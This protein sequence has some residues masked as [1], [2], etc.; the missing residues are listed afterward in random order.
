MARYMEDIGADLRRG[1]DVLAIGRLGGA[2][3]RAAR[4]RARHHHAPSRAS[5][6]TGSGGLASVSAGISEALIETAFGLAVAIPSVLGFNYLNERV[7]REETLLNNAAGELLD[8]D[9]GLARG[10]GQRHHGPVGLVPSAASSPSV[11]RSRG[12]A[13]AAAGPA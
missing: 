7:V 6:T 4:H 9:R 13:H 3:R 5:P 11:S 10:R 2:V 8:R 1:L 12:S